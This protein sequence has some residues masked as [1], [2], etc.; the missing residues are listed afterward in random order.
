MVQQSATDAGEQG[1]NAAERKQSHQ[2]TNRIATEVAQERAQVWVAGLIFHGRRR[3]RHAHIGVPGGLFPSRGGGG[4]AV[5]LLPLRLFVNGGG[6][7]NAGFRLSGDVVYN[8]G[9]AGDAAFAL[10][11][12]LFVSGSGGGNAGFRLSGAIIYNGGRGGNARL[13]RSDRWGEGSHQGGGQCDSCKAQ[14]VGEGFHWCSRYVVVSN[15]LTETMG[16]GLALT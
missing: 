5:L 12:R 11:L 9:R 14:A 4:N 3:R 1:D 16:E 7:R 10:P 6:G 15:R 13:S 2:R 8:G